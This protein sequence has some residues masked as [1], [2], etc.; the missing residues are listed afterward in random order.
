MC[1]QHLY[2]CEGNAEYPA[3][4]EQFIECAHCRQ[5]EC[6]VPDEVAHIDKAEE[7]TSSSIQLTTEIM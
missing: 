7:A 6:F 2:W 5:E 1:G 3:H 4:I